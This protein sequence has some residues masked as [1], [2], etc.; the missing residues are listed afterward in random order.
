MKVF[1]KAHKTDEI[2]ADYHVE[3]P[4]ETKGGKISLTPKDGCSGDEYE[5]ACDLFVDLYQQMCQAMK[6]ERFTLKSEKD[7]VR[8]RRKILEMSKTFPVYVELVRDKTHWELYGE[9][10]HLEAALEFLRKEEIEITRE[11]GKENR[12]GEFQVPRDDKKAMN[13]DPPGSQTKDPLETYI[14]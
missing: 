9:E 7:F 12:A 4:K 11:S 1:V 5:E 13:V 14:G 10:R 6:M 8:T 2:E 3:V